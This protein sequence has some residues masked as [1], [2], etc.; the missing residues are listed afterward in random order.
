LPP[1]PSPLRVS[2]RR[3]ELVRQ[4]ARYDEEN[5]ASRPLLRWAVALLALAVLCAAAY[6][7]RG[8]IMAAWPQSVR[9]YAALGLA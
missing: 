8:Q 6:V 9:I 1:S 7:W 5:G 2:A 4:T 3:D